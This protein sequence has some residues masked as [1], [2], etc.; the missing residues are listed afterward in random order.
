MK[1]SKYSYYYCQTNVRLFGMTR[2]RKSTS[3]EIAFA[4]ITERKIDS[5]L[6]FLKLKKVTF[7]VNMPLFTGMYEKFRFIKKRHLS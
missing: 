1:I 2:P 5:E 3:F 4:F 6:E 7:M